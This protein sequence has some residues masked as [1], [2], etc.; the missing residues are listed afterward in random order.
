M[1]IHGV[2]IKYC[3]PNIFGEE[4]V[5]KILFKNVTLGEFLA[6]KMI[7]ESEHS[8]LFVIFGVYILN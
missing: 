4:L 8:E 1:Q 6:V 3:R 2:W 5:F 7:F